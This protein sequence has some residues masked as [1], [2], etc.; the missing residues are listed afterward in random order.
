LRKCKN[1]TFGSK[2]FLRTN[3]GDLAGDFDCELDTFLREVLEQISFE[4]ARMPGVCYFQLSDFEKIWKNPVFAMD[5][6]DSELSITHS[7]EWA[8][9]SLS[10]LLAV[11]Y[12]NY[13]PT[14]SL[15]FLASI[16]AAVFMLSILKKYHF[17]KKNTKKHKRQFLQ[18]YFSYR[19][20]G[21]SH[22]FWK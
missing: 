15:W 3:D 12:W 10:Y 22:K 21:R 11:S 19:E 7:Y 13:L 20:R 14:L 9:N 5:A 16:E 18:R 2:Y 17:F 4:E 1:H 8:Q 6:R